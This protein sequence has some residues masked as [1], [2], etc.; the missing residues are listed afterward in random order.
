MLTGS[1]R[2]VLDEYAVIGTFLWRCDGC[3]IAG[4]IPV[5]QRFG[6][7]SSLKGRAYDRFPACVTRRHSRLSPKMAGQVALIGKTG[8]QG[9]LGQRKLRLFQHLLDMVQPPA[10]QIAVRWH[11]YGLVK[12]ARK[13]IPGKPGHGGE[14][15]E[16]DSTVKVSFDVIAEST[17][18]SWG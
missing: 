13:M 18:E 9:Y 17:R 11:P 16:A 3:H 5:R 4:V 1:W 2:P 12:G 14:R 6:A 10:Q 7:L 8:R 15:I